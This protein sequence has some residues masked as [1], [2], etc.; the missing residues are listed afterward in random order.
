MYIF[1]RCFANEYK[2]LHIIYN[3]RFLSRTTETRRSNP[4]SQATENFRKSMHSMTIVISCVSLSLFLSLLCPVTNF[5]IQI[6]WQPI[7]DNYVYILAIAD[8]AEVARSRKSKHILL[9]YHYVI[10]YFNLNIYILLS[11]LLLCIHVLSI[12]I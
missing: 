3:K 12:S 5:D 10:C 11:S 2:P 6:I 8:S 1:I 4:Q 9:L 7:F